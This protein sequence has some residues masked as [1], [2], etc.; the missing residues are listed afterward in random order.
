MTITNAQMFHFLPQLE[1]VMD[2]E[3]FF[4]IQL[5]DGKI[6]MIAFFDDKLFTEL[7]ELGFN[8]ITDTDTICCGWERG[9]FS[10]NQTLSD[11]RI[12]WTK[13]EIILTK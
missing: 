1:N 9:K 6:K 5:S 10:T 4:N 3:K 2:I 7:K 8:F 13:I 12:L 11:S